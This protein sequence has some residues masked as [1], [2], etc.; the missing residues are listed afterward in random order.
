MLNSLFGGCK[1]PCFPQEYANKLAA[2]D[3]VA[4]SHE[5]TVYGENLYVE[6]GSAT[7]SQDKQGTCV[8]AVDSWYN[9][10]SLYQF[11]TP[12]FSNKTGKCY[13]L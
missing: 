6:F 13:L 4:L 12:G 1:N 10:I 11:D 8:K 2:A 5:K 9:E 7:L 3:S